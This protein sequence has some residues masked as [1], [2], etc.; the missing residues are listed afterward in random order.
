MPQLALPIPDVYASVTR[1]V[2]VSIIRAIMNVTGIKDDTFIEFAG[3]NEAVPTWLTTL[4]QKVYNENNTA[5][6]PFYQKIKVDYQEEVN[7]DPILST[8]YHYND[9]MLAWN[10][11][12]RKINVSP[13]REQVKA[14]LNFTYRTIDKNAAQNWRSMM[15]R[16]IMRHFIDETFNAAF[17]YVMPVQVVAMLAIFHEMK[18]KIAGDGDTF[19][20]YLKNNAVGDLATMVDNAGRNATYVFREQQLDILGN[21]EFSAPPIEEK[22]PDG[23]CYDITFTYRFSYD[24]PIGM[25][26]KYPL[27]IHNQL[28]PP[29]LRKDRGLY[30]PADQRGLSSGSTRRYYE[31]FKNFTWSA[32]DPIFNIIPFYDDWMPTQVVADTSPIAQ[33]LIR[34]DQDNPKK[35]INLRELGKNKFNEQFLEYIRDQR[36]MVPRATACAA[37]IS[38]YENDRPIDQRDIFIDEDLNIFC[39]YDLD[40]KSVYHVRVNVFTQLLNLQ[41]FA[42]RY[43]QEHPDT[44]N[45]IVDALD[46]FFLK[47]GGVYP[48][49][50]NGKFV[51]MDEYFRVARELRV[52]AERFY[53]LTYKSIILPTVL[54]YH[55]QVVKE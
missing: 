39:Q 31:L 10:D 11:P 16:K 13:F 5:K 12:K 24:R 52:T 47:N 33:F 34:V 18:E 19:E 51:T 28:I 26:V 38:V 2:N 46:P 54:G 45:M 9:L 3:E 53:S 41:P 14:T 50:L 8:A 4:D 30:S 40:V 44:L 37:H 49:A 27:V 36:L 21:F 35:V 25:I 15:R 55:F 48:K 29:G 43:L 22:L 6:F 23:N 1:R 32:A 42:V 17:Y 20:D 7:D